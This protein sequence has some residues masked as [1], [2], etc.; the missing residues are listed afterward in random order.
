MTICRSVFLVHSSCPKRVLNR[1]AIW[2]D[3]LRVTDPP[4]SHPARLKP[5][6]QPPKVRKLI[7]TPVQRRQIT[8]RNRQRLLILKIHNP[9]KSEHLSTAV[10]LTARPCIFPDPNILPRLTPLRR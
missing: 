7:Q 4:S 1:Q 10:F 9:V 8:R 6:G 5:A 2:P 3:S